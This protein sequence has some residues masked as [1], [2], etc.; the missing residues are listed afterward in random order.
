MQWCTCV[1]NVT[2]ISFFGHGKVFLWFSVVCAC[3]TST[4]NNNLIEFGSAKHLTYQRFCCHGDWI[5][6]WSKCSILIMT[7]LLC[8]WSDPERA[9]IVRCMA[10]VPV[11]M[12]VYMCLPATISYAMVCRNTSLWCVHIVLLTCL[13]G[14]AQLCGT[15]CCVWARACFKGAAWS[16]N[17]VRSA[18]ARA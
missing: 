8:T 3:C 13:D 12:Y 2:Y 17:R 16:N 5:L 4:I 15:R 7:M 18:L 11:T 10:E 1:C 9:H 14:L 6:I